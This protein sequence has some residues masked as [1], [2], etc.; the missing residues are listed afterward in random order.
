MKKGDKLKCLET[1]KN[2]LGMTLFQKGNIY[3]VLYINNED[4]EV[5]VCLNHTLYGNEYNQFS[6]KWVNEKF[7]LISA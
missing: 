4:V 1:V 6:L 2:F 7:K 3:E 5:M